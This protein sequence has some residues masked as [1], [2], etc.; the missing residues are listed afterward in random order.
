MVGLSGNSTICKSW[1]CPGG[2]VG[3]ERHL[4]FLTQPPFHPR[5]VLGLEVAEIH[6]WKSPQFGCR[7]GS[8]SAGS[9]GTPSSDE[10]LFQTSDSAAD[11]PLLVMLFPYDKDGSP[12][13]LN[14]ELAPW[15]SLG[16]SY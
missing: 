11:T 9:L 13:T 6:T 14:S 10:L 4:C 5:V 2:E 1:I 16:L 15:D 7:H 12:G 3:S 8:V